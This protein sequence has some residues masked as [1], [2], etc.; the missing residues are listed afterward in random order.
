M[1]IVVSREKTVVVVVVAEMHGWQAERRWWPAATME[2]T[3][4][5]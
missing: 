4:T 3:F 2:T 1:P 5:P